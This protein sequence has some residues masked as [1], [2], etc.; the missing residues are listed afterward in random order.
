MILLIF[1]LRAF[2]LRCL[3]PVTRSVLLLLLLSLLLCFGAFSLP[4]ESKKEHYKSSVAFFLL[5][6][7]FFFKRKKFSLSLIFLPF[8]PSL[9]P[10]FSFLF[11]PPSSSTLHY[12]M[13]AFCCQGHTKQHQQFCFFGLGN[14]SQFWWTRKWWNGERERNNTHQS[15]THSVGRLFHQLVCRWIQ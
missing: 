10:H 14:S 12:I 1:T 11:L 8:S 9:F 2:S 13:N 7:S 15:L 6:L 4:G 3:D 5:P